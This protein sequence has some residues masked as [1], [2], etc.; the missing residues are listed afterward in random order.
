MVNYVRYTLQAI[1][2]APISGS[3]GHFYPPKI[4]KIQN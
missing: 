3:N 4:E 2:L 1:V